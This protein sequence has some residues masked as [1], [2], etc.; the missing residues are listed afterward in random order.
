MDK[1]YFIKNHFDSN[2]FSDTHDFLSLNNSNF[3]LMTLL[4]ESIPWNLKY[5]IRKAQLQGKLVTYLD[6]HPEMTMVVGWTKLYD[7][8][9]ISAYKLWTFHFYYQHSN[10]ACIRIIYLSA[11]TCISFHDFSDRWFLLVR[12]I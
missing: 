4:N 9:M 7:K 2:I 3:E 12:K 8:E 11:G 6:L 1:S 5:S 10:S